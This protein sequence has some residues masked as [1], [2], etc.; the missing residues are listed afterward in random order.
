AREE[1]RPAEEIAL[2]VVRNGDASVVGFSMSEADVRLIMKQ[3][4][5]A[6]A[7]D[8]GTQLITEDTVP[9]PRSYGTFPRKIGESALGKRIVPLEQALRSCTGLPADILRLPERGYLKAGYVADVVVLDPKTFRE[10]TTFTKPHQYAEG[11]RYLFVNGV[12]TID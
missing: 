1:K 11:V 10:K 9:H 5:V 3:P 12:R 6:T 4:Y 2:E 8:G 7:S